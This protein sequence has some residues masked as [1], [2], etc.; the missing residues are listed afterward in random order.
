MFTSRRARLGLAIGLLASSGALGCL[1][2]A[3]SSDP[4]RAPKMYRI[5]RTEIET[6]VSQGRETIYDVIVAL[7]PHMLGSRYGEAAGSPSGTASQM[8][9]GVRVY[10]DGVALG[11]VRALA[12][13]LANTVVEVRWL[14]GIDATTMY[15]TGN[16]DGAILVTSLTGGARRP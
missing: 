6:E 8:R 4:A 16:T 9:R 5:S 13:I 1:Q 7:R 2:P 12:S 3:R 10:L 15:G 14:S 11:D